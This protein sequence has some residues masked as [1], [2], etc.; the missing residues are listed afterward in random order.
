MPKIKMYE[1]TVTLKAESKADAKIKLAG[2]ELTIL[3]VT[4]V[5]G[6]GPKVADS[7]LT[8]T[9]KKAERTRKRRKASGQGVNP[10]ER[11]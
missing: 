4:K 2:S 11:R 9:N 1:A 5:D 3:R 8:I 6:P 10:V 7:E